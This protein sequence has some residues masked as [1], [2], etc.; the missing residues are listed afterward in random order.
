MRIGLV[1]ATFR[2]TCDGGDCGIENH[3]FGASDTE[4]LL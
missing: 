1:G 4:A 2:L 3:H